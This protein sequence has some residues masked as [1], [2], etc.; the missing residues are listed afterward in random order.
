MEILGNPRGVF[1]LNNSDTSVGS[2]FIKE[3]ICSILEVREIDLALL[4][5]VM[6]DGYEVIDER[7]VQKA[8]Y[9][10]QIPNAIPVNQSSLDELILISIIRKTIPECI[11]ERQFRVGRFQIDL[12]LTVNQNSIFV[13][14][15]GPSHFANS[16]YGVPKDPRIKKKKVE[17][18]TGLEVINW[19][20]WIQRC[21]ANVKVLFNRS[22]IGLG[23]LWSTNVH[24]GEFLFADSA[25]LIIECTKRFNALDTHGFGYFYG[26]K[27]RGRNNPEHPII[28]KILKCKADLKILLPK[29]FE[30]KNY[31]L[32][33]KLRE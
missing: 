3:D 27:T 32:P 14:F 10:G 23:A 6:I 1:D 31:W 24:F 13:E 19:P 7:Q 4:K 33:E 11:I 16:R 12:K 17:D 15:D 29:G 26:P 21:N 9:S 20:Y 22:E 28:E 8:W 25:Q 30:D 18:K 5:F 2:Y